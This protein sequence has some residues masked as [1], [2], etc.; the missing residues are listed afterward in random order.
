MW[1]RRGP[2]WTRQH[3][4]RKT[5]ALIVPAI[6]VVFL[7][8]FGYHAYHG[9]LGIDS[10]HHLEMRAA[11]LQAELDGIRERRATLEHRIKLLQDGT[12]EKDMLDEQARRAL[13]LSHPDEV[14]IL[15]VR[16]Q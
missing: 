6:T 2:F 10:R 1:K 15:R 16:N 3:K 5:G 7:A 13:S 9:E 12:I 8:Y 11:K 14:T 4:N